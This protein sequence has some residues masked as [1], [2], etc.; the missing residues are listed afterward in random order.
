LLI[1]FSVASL[2]SDD[3]D[4]IN[5]RAVFLNSAINRLQGQA[6]AYSVKQVKSKTVQWANNPTERNWVNASDAVTFTAI[7]YKVDSDVTIKTFPKDGATIR[8]QTVGQRGR[9][10]QPQ[11]AKGLTI[12]VET[13]P[14]GRYHIWSERNG[15]PT[16]NMT[17]TY[18]IL[19]NKEEVSINEKDTTSEKR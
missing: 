19:K 6:P 18:E 14:I 3:K 7:N 16:S 15:K 2:S 17:H 1:S 11:T 8:Y 4:E 13:M 10:E 12:C 5:E 9:S